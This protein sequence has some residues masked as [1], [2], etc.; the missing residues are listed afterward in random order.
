MQPAGLAA[1]KKRK[2]QKSRIY[3]YENRPHEFPAALEKNF[4][5][6]KAAWAFF[7]QQSPSYR[8]MV[9]YW[10]VSARKEETQLSRLAK[11]IDASAGGKRLV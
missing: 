11:A 4:R 9:V 3:S 1:F 10:V 8:R 2:K 6:N 7:S 5:A